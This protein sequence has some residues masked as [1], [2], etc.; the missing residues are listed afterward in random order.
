MPVLGYRRYGGTG[1][2]YP[3]PPNLPVEISVKLLNLN[4]S[5]SYDNINGRLCLT[6]Q[7]NSFDCIKICLKLY[8]KLA[9]DGANTACN[10]I[11][12]FEQFPIET[13]LCSRKSKTII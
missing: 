5:S 10:E 2:P 11:D 8:L 3:P 9:K 4:I 13:E 1:G 12:L 6:S 7:R